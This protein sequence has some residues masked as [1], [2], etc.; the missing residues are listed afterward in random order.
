MKNNFFII[1]TNTLISA[2]LLPDSVTKQ[3]YNKAVRLG[4]LSASI[5][6]YDELREVFLR[7]KFDKYVSPEKRLLIINDIKELLVFIEPTEKILDCRDPKDNKFLELAIVAGAS[8]LI[9]GD[10]D[11]LILHPFRNIPILNA[12][13]FINNF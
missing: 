7:P 5:E 4:K 1:D 12:I 8:C 11:L 9:S 6:T 2:F 10:K 13:D 3:A